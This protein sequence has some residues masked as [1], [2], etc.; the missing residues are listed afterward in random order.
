MLQ[1][2]KLYTS[3][4]VL[5]ISTEKP[6][7]GQGKNFSTRVQMKG[8]FFGYVSPSVRWWQKISNNVTTSLDATFLR[9]D[10]NYPFTLENGK[11][12]T[13]ER[14]NNSAIDS[15]H[16]EGNVYAAFPAAANCR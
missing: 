16:A 2:A 11:Y 10:G 1:S 12:V 7:F 4:A 15:P 14:R 5:G 6:H 9:A 3:A 8:Y 13:R